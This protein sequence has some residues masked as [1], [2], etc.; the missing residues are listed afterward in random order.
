[1]NR[2]I[3]L[4]ALVLTLSSCL[5]QI[6]WE[7]AENPSGRLVVEGL[8]TSERKAHTVKLTQ[9]MPVIVDTLPPVV[10]G[11]VVTIDDGTQVFTLTEKE[12]G[13]YQTDTTVAGEVGNTY[14]LT[15]NFNGEIFEAFAAMIAVEPPS[16]IGVTARDNFPAG[17][18]EEGDFF[19]FI[20]RNNFGSSAPLHYQI[21]S[22][23]PENV[24]DFYPPEWQMP[25]WLVW[26]LENQGLTL[27]DSSYYLHPGLEPPAIFTYGET[28][29]TRI[30]L[31]TTITETFGSMT[32]EHYAFVRAI[33][34]ESEWRGLGPFGY[35]PADA[36]TNLSNGAL[37][38]FA[39]SE[40]IRIQQVIE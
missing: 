8:I 27:Q 15:I 28:N 1:M 10:T 2:I 12:P 25:N 23:L 30:T 40:V 14:H 17:A 38:Y 35:I 9:T 21:R 4:L 31:G 32:E 19:Q 26:Q 11:A 37:G 39:A 13:I 33:L 29:E 36:P 6:A 7:E 5:D 3:I 22:E 34:S 20:Y 24:S 18:G 16:S